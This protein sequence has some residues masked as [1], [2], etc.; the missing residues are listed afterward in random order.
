MP[1]V[2]GKDNVASGT[3]FRASTNVVP[4]SGCDAEPVTLRCL[5]VDDNADFGDAAADL[6]GGQGISVIG[7]ATSAGDA[8][9]KADL[10]RPQ[11]ALVDIKLGEESGFEV[12]RQLAMRAEAPDVILISTE[13]GQYFESLIEA[14]PALG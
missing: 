10:F 8:V 7:V 13:E 9:R 11:L 14:S 2:R 3:G 5:I 4:K 6:L 1:A 12:A